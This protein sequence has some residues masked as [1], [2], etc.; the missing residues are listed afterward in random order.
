MT[1]L[2]RP[3]STQGPIV[4]TIDPRAVAS[5]APAAERRPA[6]R[7]MRT[8]QR[9]TT[10]VSLPHLLDQDAA[11]TLWL[12]RHVDVALIAP[13]NA[14]LYCPGLEL[15][16]WRLVGRGRVELHGWPPRSTACLADWLRR[17]AVGDLVGDLSRAG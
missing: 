16:S 1:T 13:G 8:A 15:L 12:P 11:V 5:P 7:V 2:T 14:V 9:E 17:V 3:D 10:P 4:T 6:V